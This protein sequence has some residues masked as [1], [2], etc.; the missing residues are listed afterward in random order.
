MTATTP[1]PPTPPAGP[2]V[3]LGPNPR[4]RAYH[5]D[6]PLALA[7]GRFT[8]GL[9]RSRR[10]AWLGPPIVRAIEYGYLAVLGFAQDVPAPLIYVLLAVLAYHHYDTVYRTR[11]KLWPQRWVFLA[12]LGWEGRLL[13]V[14]AAALL[15]VLPFV[16]AVLAAYLGVMFGVESVTTWVR[17]GREEGA[18]V[19]LEKDAEEDEPEEVG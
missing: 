14:T 10:L 18:M 11:Q 7:L 17:A 13:V 15:G 12:G 1:P 4:L 2:T 3:P 5:D 6:G 16:Y 8:A 9:P 19:D